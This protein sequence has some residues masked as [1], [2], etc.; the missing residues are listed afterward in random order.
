VILPESP[1]EKILNKGDRRVG[2]RLD[3]LEDTEEEDPAEGFRRF[4]EKQ[5]Q[6]RHGDIDSLNNFLRNSEE[7]AHRDLDTVA[8]QLEKGE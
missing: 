4:Q 8:R 7:R 2:D 6:L 1:L 5:Q 3:H